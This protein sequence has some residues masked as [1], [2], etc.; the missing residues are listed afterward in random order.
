MSTFYDAPKSSVAVFQYT[1]PLEALKIL[2]SALQTD[3]KSIIC[4]SAFATWYKEFHVEWNEDFVEFSD[5][6]Y[7]NVEKIDREVVIFA[8]FDVFSMIFGI[9]KTLNLIKTLKTKKRIFIVTSLDFPATPHLEHL[10]NSTFKVKKSANPE[11]FECQTTVFDKKGNLTIMDQIITMPPSGTKPTFKT[12]KKV[13]NS[14]ENSIS[15]GISGI[16]LGSESGKA[17]MDLPFFVSRQED[18]V[19]LRDAATKKIRVGGQI[20]YEPDQEDD[21]DDSDPDDD[22]NIWENSDFETFLL[23]LL[24]KLDKILIFNEIVD[25]WVLREPVAVDC[26]DFGWNFHISKSAD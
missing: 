11:I 7:K 1:D 2:R 26:S 17:A 22:L 10:T 6:S 5:E 18:G 12:V 19:A 21:L 15:A 25:L 20:V 16:S 8:D 14:A 24:L 23:N 4:H 3:K 9:S 13:E